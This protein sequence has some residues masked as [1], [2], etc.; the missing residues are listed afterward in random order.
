MKG[1]FPCT[2]SPVGAELP[3]GHTPYSWEKFGA[4]A[5]D[6][7]VPS[8]SASAKAPAPAAAGDMPP[9]GSLEAA[10]CKLDIRCGRV[11]EC[12]KVPDADSLY[13]LKIDVGENEPRQVVSSLVK[14]YKAEELQNRQVVVY[15]NIKPGKMRGFESQAMVL[16]A[17]SG[18]GTDDEKC[19]LLAPPP[20]VAEGTRP[21]C[22]GLEVGC[23]S[24]T[25]NV[26]NI[27]KVW[28]QVQPLLLTNEKF[29]A[30]FNGSVL[31]MKDAPVSAN[32]L[33]SVPIY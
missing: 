10:L 13:L 28:A 31:S 29:E 8:S 6:V 27:S 17:T 22:G 4:G 25:Q 5:R 7:A 20:G 21:M 14:H 32:S 2:W 3:P 24:A 19:E 1:G 30:T 26:K 9:E 15:C 33:S 23:L 16:A 11:K 18:K 12:R